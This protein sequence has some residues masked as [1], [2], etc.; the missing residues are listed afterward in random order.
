MPTKEASSGWTTEAGDLIRGAAG[1]MLFGIP[2][3]FTLEVWGIGSAATPAAMAVVL[4]LTFVPVILLVHTAGFR[5]STSMRLP[6]VLRESVEA[7]AVGIVAVTGV[8]ILLGEITL[9]TPLPDALGKVVYETAPF[10]VGAAVACHLL[11]RSPDEADGDP[12]DRDERGSLRGTVADLGSTVVGALFVG[13]NIAPTE[14]IPRL[15]AGSSPPALL[16]VMAASLLISYG[17]VFEAGFRNQERR[18]KQRGV[19]QHP[20][21]ETAAS[22]LTALIVSAAML[23]FFGNLRFGDP[24]PL[25]IDRVVL[26]ALPAAIGGAAGRLAI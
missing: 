25:V 23:L 24:W 26:L 12:T 13:L 7:V 16:A 2:L 6:E 21:T 1:G 20:A 9:R 18:R 15:A 14:E 10:A 22:Y 4:I 17:I 8:L 11:S 5:S 19:L 3:L